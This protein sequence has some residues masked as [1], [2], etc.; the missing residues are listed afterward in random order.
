MELNSKP[1]QSTIRP[2][3][4]QPT[5]NPQA[6]RPVTPGVA[7]QPPR[8]ATPSPVA[9]PVV[10]N[11]Q[12]QNPGAPT[13]QPTGFAPQ[14][15]PA[16]P[17]V[18]PAQPQRPVVQPQPTVNVQQPEEKPAEPETNTTEQVVVDETKTFGELNEYGS[19]KDE[20]KSFFKLAFTDYLPAALCAIALAVY[21]F[22]GFM[23]LVNA[24]GVAN[25][26]AFISRCVTVAALVVEVMRQ[27]KAKKFEFSPS[28]II[29][30]LSIFVVM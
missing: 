7:Q 23:I 19:F 4:A 9:R 22:S 11:Q 16:A 14:P 29:V 12:P 8:P 27:I 20:E 25:W 18:Q 13:P 15:K 1:N 6:S 10:N 24:Y 26:I 28:M 17:S 30:L 21:M 2:T 5:A 3:M